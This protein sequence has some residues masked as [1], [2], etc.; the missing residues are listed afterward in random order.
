MIRGLAITAAV[1]V[2]FALAGVFGVGAASP[3]A[4]LVVAACAN[5]GMLLAARFSP[6]R[7]AA[8]SG[9]G[10]R[11]IAVIEKTLPHL[12]LGLNEETAGRTVRLLHEVMRL[13][14]VGITDRERLLAFVGP[15]A[16]HHLVG[17]P[18]GTG[19]TTRVLE[20]GEMAVAGTRADI[21]CRV[22]VSCPLSSAVVAPLVCGP[23]T[24]G[25][26]KVYQ[27]HEG[28]PAPNLVDLTRALAAML[29]LQLELAQAQRDA[30]MAHVAKLDAL[31]AQIN[32]HF[33]F[34]TLNTIAMR[35]RTDPDEA[36]RLL[37]KLSDFLRYA[38]KQSGHLASFG[39]EYFFL[40]TYLFL[41]RARFGDRLRVRYDVDP[42]V[43]SIPVPVLTIQPLVENAVKHGIASK[44]DGGL[45]E[46][47]AR[48]EPIGGTLRIRVRD[49][50]TG[51]ADGRVSALLA[52][53]AGEGHALANI[54]E[55]L[56]R[57]YG[58]RASL[59]IDST[60]GRGTVVQVS[61]PVK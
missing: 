8:P 22:G 43:L 32:P 60:P 33:L 34:N 4:F 12:R 58:G 51:I 35:A 37:V 18:V 14:A 42:Q 25:A 11:M 54:H 44:P 29:S 3:W 26:L 6:T 41:E 46:V 7:S 48:L 47:K 57:L 38:M 5:A 36:R 31:R 28:T 49:D 56:V 23:H 24:V 39:E 53:A 19:L 40:R 2:G 50:G 13:E 20:S 1:A 16:D 21:E 59:D 55:R 27:T 61:L 15:G 30:Q 9:R 17:E 10:N 52:P 45:V